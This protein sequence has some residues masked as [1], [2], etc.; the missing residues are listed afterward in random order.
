[1]P[2]EHLWPVLPLEVPPP[3][4]TGAEVFSFPATVLFLD[5]LRRVRSRPVGLA[6]AGTLGALVRRLGGVPLALELAAARGRV[7][8]LEEMLARYGG[9][10]ADPDPAGRSLRDAVQASWRLLTSAERE[11]L[12]WLAVFQ[13]RWSV[14][15]AEALLDGH[16]AA[17]DVVALVDQLVGLGLVSA[18]P[19]AQ[20]MR[21]WLLDAVRA[22]ALEQARESGLLVTVRDRH[23]EVIGRAAAGIVAELGRGRRQHG[24]DRDHQIM[25]LDQLAPDVQAAVDHLRGRR[26][27]IAPSLTAYLSA[28]R[29]LRGVTAP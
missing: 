21:F 19:G 22:V 17:A 18:R 3:E 14:E 5:R 23:A 24:D 12:C 28:W 6:E 11:C 10:T 29:R 1:L 27:R 16:P 26:E 25:P 9:S 2:G 7:L 15:L 8:E 13:W 4:S 20:S